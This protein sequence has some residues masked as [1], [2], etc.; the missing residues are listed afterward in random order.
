M[1][2]SPGHVG[3][4]NED[5]VGAVPGAMVMLDGAG[6][7]DTDGICRHGVAWYSHTLGATLL[8]RLARDRG[9]DLVASLADSIDQV[10]ALHRH[11]CDIADPSSPQST[12]AIVRFEEDR[13]DYLVLA[14]AFVRGATSRAGTGS[15][16]TMPARQRRP[17]PAACLSR[18]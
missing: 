18:V 9:T 15:P 17:S 7:P 4:R 14:D 11:S 3:R 5:F 1:A 16:R 12:V 8:A 10:A 13:A 6:I 2:T